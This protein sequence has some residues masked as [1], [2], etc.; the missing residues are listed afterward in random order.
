AAFAEIYGIPMRVG[1]Y[2]AGASETDKRA[3]LRAVASIANDAAAII[4]LGMDIQFIEAQGTKGE[5]VFG[6][7]LEYL[8]KQV[9]KLV[10]GQ[11]MTADDGSSQAQAKIHDKVRL[12]ITQADCRQLA[13]TLNRD[14]IP[15]FVSLNFGPQ[16]RYPKA[17]LPVAE[18]E[19][20][21]E[22]TE[23]VARLVPMGLKV[24]QREMR[25]RIGVSEPEEDDD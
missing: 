8:D 23:A 21:K 16:D 18:P 1:K 17:T 15:W 11:T 12:D 14:L 25:Q 10:V 20:V 3:L 13:N 9:S 24:S 4:P 22:L 19:D 5:A 6:G 7:L 2:H